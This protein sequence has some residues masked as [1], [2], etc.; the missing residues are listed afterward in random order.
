MQ[1]GDQKV[2]I[3]EHLSPPVLEESTGV[4]VIAVHLIA[5]LHNM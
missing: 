2:A 3:V 5:L 4:F 1:D